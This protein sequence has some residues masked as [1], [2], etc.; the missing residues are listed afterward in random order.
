MTL[1]NSIKILNSNSY[2][3]HQGEQ[4]LQYEVKNFNCTE[5]GESRKESHGASNGTDLVSK[6][7]ADIIDN[8]VIGGC[9]EVDLNHLQRMIWQRHSIK[10]PY[11]FFKNQ[12][13][14]L[15]FFVSIVG[16]HQGFK[17]YLILDVLTVG[18]ILK[19]NISVE[20]L[21]IYLTGVLQLFKACITVSAVWCACLWRRI[22]WY[23]IWNK[24]CGPCTYLII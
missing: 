10:P 7:D 15:N 17:H 12:I 24:I 14:Y 21:T 16:L 4:K 3:W 19:D 11:F 9:A 13:F 8:L 2:F 23:V 6:W 20:T 1:R 22:D 18:W 5:N